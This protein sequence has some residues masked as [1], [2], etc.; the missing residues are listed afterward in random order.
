MDSTVIAIF[1]NTAA[2]V[3]L[4]FTYSYRQGKTDGKLEQIDKRIERIERITNNKG[5]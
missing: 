1:T 2:F 5:D 3:A 4:I